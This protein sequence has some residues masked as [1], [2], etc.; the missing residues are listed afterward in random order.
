MALETATAIAYLGL[1]SNLGDRL[2]VMS[3]AVAAL[4]DH[5]RIQVD[6]PGGV[7]SLYETSPVGGPPDQ[8]PYLNSALRVRTSL[9][10]LALLDTVL[11]IETSLGRVRRERWGPRLIDIDLLLY[12]DV[13]LEHQRLTLPH[14]RLHER[15]FVLEPLCEIAAEVTHPLFQVTLAE[16]LR[17][18]GVQRAEDKAALTA[19]SGWYGDIIGC[20]GGPRVSSSGEA[21]EGATMDR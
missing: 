21:D 6:F 19:D 16:L 11:S 18:L 3:A 10:P 9:A 8:P 2:A 14:P 1:G 12:D 4:D 13:V 5:P 17:R 15:R 20:S 7:T